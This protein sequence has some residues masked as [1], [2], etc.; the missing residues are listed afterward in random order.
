MPDGK[1]VL[2]RSTRGARNSLWVQPVDG[3]GPA[4]LLHG[5]PTAKVEEGMVSPDGRYVLFQ[6][7]A[8]G[9]GDLWFKAT[10]ADSQPH[11]VATTAV[12]EL[13]PRFS[14]DGK[15]IVYSSSESG[16]PQV[17]AQPF[18]SL[19]TRH[20]VSLDGGG[21]PLWSRDGTI[22][23]T[24]G[25]TLMAAKVSTSPNF[26]V[27]SRR[28]V[29]ENRFSYMTIHADFDVF[30]NGRVLG[31]QPTEEEVRVVVVHNWAASIRT[32]LTAAPR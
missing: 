30:T 21:T 10:H 15:W 3:A 12:A 27:L 19:A 4:R 26:S 18:P 25:R 28:V 11:P 7:D 9:I 2:F 29:N 32:L 8:V 6:L 31:L 14:P 24:R 1:S 20:Q 17:Y 23:F 5:H 13:S 22:Y 16:P